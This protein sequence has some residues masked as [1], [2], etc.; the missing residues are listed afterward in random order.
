MFHYLHDSITDYHCVT[1]V[2]TEGSLLRR[3]YGG[4]PFTG[5]TQDAQGNFYGTNYQ[6]VG[7]GLRRNTVRIHVATGH[8]QMA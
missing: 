4:N 3:P 5:V 1:S 6:G 7:A 2:T 8:S